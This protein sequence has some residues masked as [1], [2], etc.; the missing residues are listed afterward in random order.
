MALASKDLALQL[1]CRVAQAG[2]GHVS[3]P[4][5]LRI[6]ILQTEVGSARDLNCKAAYTQTSEARGCHLGRGPCAMGKWAKELICR[7]R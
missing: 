7:E 5:R 1:G 4:K 3:I 2:P 6:G